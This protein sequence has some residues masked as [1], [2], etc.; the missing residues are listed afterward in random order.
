[1]LIND[2]NLTVCHRACQHRKILRAA[3]KCIDQDQVFVVLLQ[4]VLQTTYVIHI[5]PAKAF[6]KAWAPS[7]SML[8]KIHGA[9]SKYVT[10]V[11]NRHERLWAVNSMLCI[12]Q[13]KLLG[14]CHLNRVVQEDCTGRQNVLRAIAPSLLREDFLSMT[15]CN[16]PWV[17]TLMFY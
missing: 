8:C 13:I 17:P 2:M 14:L 4:K 1:M 15:A 10:F 16:K 12:N 5:L 11:H 6:I 7:K 9:Y 3:A